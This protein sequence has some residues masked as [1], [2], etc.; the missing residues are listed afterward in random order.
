VERPGIGRA[1]EKLQQ[2]LERLVSNIHGCIEMSDCKVCEEVKRGVSKLV[3]QIGVG[4][5]EFD[6][7]GREKHRSGWKR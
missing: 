3:E 1:S 6:G 2:N 5:W 4:P 7:Q